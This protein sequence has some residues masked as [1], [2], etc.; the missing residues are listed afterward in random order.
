MDFSPENYS[1]ENIMEFSKVDWH[2]E[3]SLEIPPFQKINLTYQYSLALPEANQ[4]IISYVCFFF[5]LF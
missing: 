1:A 4:K 5:K 2:D 3:V